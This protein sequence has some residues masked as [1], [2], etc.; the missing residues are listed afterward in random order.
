[1]NKSIYYIAIFVLTI[2][3]VLVVAAMKLAID[4]AVII[5]ILASLVLLAIK[6]V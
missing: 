6:E 1:M 4:Y 5:G 2:V 3:A